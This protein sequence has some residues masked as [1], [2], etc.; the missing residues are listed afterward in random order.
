MQQKIYYEHYHCRQRQGGH[1]PCPPAVGGRLQPDLN[2]HGL[3]DVCEDCDVIGV[4]VFLLAVSPS[5]NLYHSPT[6]GRKPRSGCGKAGAV[7]PF[8]LEEVTL[9]HLSQNFFEKTSAFNKFL[10]AFWDKIRHNKK[11]CEK[12]FNSCRHCRRNEVDYGK[13]SWNHLP[14]HPLPHYP[15][16]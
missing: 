15:T 13:K 11:V 3:E 9:W 5:A 8:H 7:K 14:W 12:P 6:A 1:N 16:G 2:P 10:L 4:L